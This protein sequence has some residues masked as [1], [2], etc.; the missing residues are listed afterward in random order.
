M[1]KDELRPG[2]KPE[3]QP[4]KK[5]L[6]RPKKE[7]QRDALIKLEQFLDIVRILIFGTQQ[8]KASLGRCDARGR[9]GE[10]LTTVR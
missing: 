6:P 3:K 2:D 8:R 10:N 7:Y 1:N 4:E 9:A 5:K